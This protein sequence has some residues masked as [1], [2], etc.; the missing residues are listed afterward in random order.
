MTVPDGGLGN[1]YFGA[2]AICKPNSTWQKEVPTQHWHG[3]SH[4]QHP[5]RWRLQFA[6]LRCLKCRG[7]FGM[8]WL[9]GRPRKNMKPHISWPPRWNTLFIVEVLY[10]SF[11]L[12]R[13]ARQ[14]PCQRW[15]NKICHCVL[16]AHAGD[17][18]PAFPPA[19][20]VVRW[21]LLKGRSSGAAAKQFGPPMPFGHST[22]FP[23]KAVPP[24]PPPPPLGLSCMTSS[25]VY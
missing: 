16:P 12:L 1:H 23:F 8:L 10:G 14:A 11:P 24:P 13:L 4:I 18:L 9:Q 20:R 22:P 5:L 3:G 25:M 2:V 21:A 19:R 6:S 7:F 15:R 17:C